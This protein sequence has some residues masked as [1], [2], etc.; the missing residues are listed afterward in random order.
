MKSGNVLAILA[1]LVM[2]VGNGTAIAQPA[3]DIE[4]TTPLRGEQI[5]LHDGD[6]TREQW[7]RAF[8]QNWVRNVD[9]STMFKVG[10]MNG[11]GNGKAVIVVPGGGYMFVS[12]DSE[13]IRVA[14]RLAAEGYTAF[15][16]K[17]RHRAT[18]RSNEAFVADLLA[19]WEQI[20]ND[21]LADHAPA[22]DDLAS[23]L[24]W[25]QGHADALSID[26]QKIGVIGFSAGARTAIRL[27]EQRKEAVLLDHV[28]LIYPPMEQ[29]IEGGPR[30][31]LFMA[32]AADDP[33]FRQGGLNMIER[34]LSESN[35]VEFHLYSNGEHGFGMIPK[36]TTSDGWI[37]NYVD[38]L[39]VQ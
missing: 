5:V 2:T 15:V 35:K 39:A 11:R 8:G 6:E 38:W 14:E 16:L 1:A 21:V 18:P 7:V 31:D 36:G 9:R 23:A 20:G 29:T 33:L 12:I 10:P 32:I 3:L 34:W 4:E 27:L 24:S 37:E 30:P 26:P 19:D 13:G 28:A 17:Y 22:V 25:V